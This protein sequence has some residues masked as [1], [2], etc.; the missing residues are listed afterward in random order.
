[1]ARLWTGPGPRV[2]AEGSANTAS[3]LDNIGETFSFMAGLN[4]LF[5]HGNCIKYRGPE[6]PACVGDAASAGS[7]KFK[8]IS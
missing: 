7:M 3:I 6:A 1:M 2:P 8:F 5:H 4:I